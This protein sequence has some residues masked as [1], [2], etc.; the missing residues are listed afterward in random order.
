MATADATVAMPRRPAALGWARLPLW[1]RRTILFALLIA[2]WQAYVSLAH[3]NPFF[4]ATPW[5]TAKE[6]WDGFAH[7][8]LA[9]PTWTTLKILLEGVGIGIL[10]AAV[11]TAFATLTAVGD[12]LLA[13]L[14]SILNPLPG[15]AVLPL[16][17]LWFGISTK[18][19]LFVIANAT[20]WPI[21]I[22]VTTGFKTANQTLV[23]VGRNIGLSRVRQITDVLA[24][25]ALPYVIT[26]V[27]TAWAF[28]WRTIIAAELVFGVAGENGG[29]G[30]YINN[31][32]N[33]FLTS[34][35]F[36]G[37]VVIAVL[38]VVFETLFGMLERRTV[39]RWGM[40]TS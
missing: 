27:K 30:F 28:G 12:D 14:T 37:L 2:G 10:V 34:R 39:V 26:G 9:R 15:V 35:M 40:K 17:M 24:P 29:L 6:I 11:L 22:A 19:I 21:A 32:R 38:G 1:V 20:I 16:A 5:Q 18:A 25:A 7:G 36:A 4:F 33:Y 13:L 31:A 3:P 23:S 8:S